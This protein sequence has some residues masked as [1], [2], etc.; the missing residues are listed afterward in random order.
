MS[1]RNKCGIVNYL[2]ESKPSFRKFSEAWEFFLFRLFPIFHFGWFLFYG[3]LLLIIES[4]IKTL[5]FTFYITAKKKRKI[6]MSADKN[7]KLLSF[8][9]LSK[10]LAV[11]ALLVL[12]F[13]RRHPNSLHANT[14]RTGSRPRRDTD[15]IML[16]L[17]FSTFIWK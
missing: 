16:Y 12:E 14:Y 17:C 15:Y 3:G 1:F 5:I 8:V 9:R 2:T 13:Y 6:V 10:V 11:V 7:K 4:I